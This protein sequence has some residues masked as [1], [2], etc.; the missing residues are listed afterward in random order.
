MDEVI[1]S[2]KD[3]N[4]RTIKRLKLSI[5]E[6]GSWDAPEDFALLVR[7]NSELGPWG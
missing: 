6:L 1:R 7:F 4:G 2:G 5:A 3:G